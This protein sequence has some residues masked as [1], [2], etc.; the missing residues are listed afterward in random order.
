MHN[1]EKLES[2]IGDIMVYI[3]E[4]NRID[5]LT[6]EKLSK[7]VSDLWDITGAMKDEREENYKRLNAV[8]NTL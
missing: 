2:A 6:K 3:E 5:R 1:I 4:N 8:L 7:Q